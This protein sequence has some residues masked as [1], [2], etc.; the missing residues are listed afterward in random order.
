MFN[1]R[2]RGDYKELVEI[3]H[4]DAEEFVKLAEAFLNGIKKL[5]DISMTL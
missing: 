5:F 2:Q 4:E 1:F 3:S